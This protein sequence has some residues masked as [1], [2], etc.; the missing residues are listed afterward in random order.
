MSKN[1]RILLLVLL[2]IIFTCIFYIWITFSPT[3]AMFKLIHNRDTEIEL[4]HA[5]TA[6]IF[7]NHPAAYDMIDPRLKHRLDEWMST[8]QNKRCTRLP[9]YF[10]VGSET[11]TTNSYS[12][13]FTCYG[14]NGWVD[15]DIEN[16]VIRDMK[17]IDW[18]YIREGN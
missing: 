9:D 5:F 16:I 17:V 13:G 6:A 12:V 11:E 3:V 2:G 15:L 1:T 18:G 4:A 14:V 7:T 10:L 8:H